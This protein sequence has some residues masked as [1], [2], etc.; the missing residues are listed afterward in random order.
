MR[1]E[2]AQSPGAFAMLT[3]L[4]ELGAALIEAFI[5]VITGSECGTNRRSEAKCPSAYTPAARVALT[6]QCSWSGSWAWDVPREGTLS[7]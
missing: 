6:D 5:A 2:R 3:H 4:G 7:K 1:L